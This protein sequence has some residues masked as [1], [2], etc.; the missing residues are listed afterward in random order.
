MAAKQKEIKKSKKMKNVSE[1][2]VVVEDEGRQSKI[3]GE[4]SSEIKAKEHKKQL[5]RLQEKDPEFYQFLQE[6][7]KELLEFDEEDEDAETEVDDEGDKIRVGEDGYE[8]DIADIDSTLEKED[9]SSKKVITT[10]MVDL[11][12]SAIREKTT[13]GAVR[14]LMKAFRTACHYGDDDGDDSSTKFSIMSSSVFN[15]IMLF[16]LNEMDR[17]FRALFDLPSSGGKKEMIIELMGTKKWKNYNHLVKSYFGNALHILNQMTD[18]EMISLTLKRLKSSSIFLAAFPSLLRRYI[19]VVIHFWGTGGDALP[20]VSFLFI[21]DLCIRVGSDCLDECFKGMYKAYVMNCQNVNATKLQHMQFLGNCVIEL[22]GVDLPAAYQHAFSFIRQLAMVLQDALSMKTDKA[23]STSD[24]KKGKAQPSMKRKEVFRKVYNWKF[25]NCLELW[26]GAICAYSSEADLR[27]LAYPL[28]QI[29]SGASRLVPTARYFPLRL[30]CVRMLNR[31]A[32]STGTFI[33]VSLLLLDMLDMK[34][35]NRPP[36]GGAGKAEDL[37]T[38]L[39]VSKST[40]R[41]KAFQEAYVLSVVD[42]VAEHLAIWSY[43]VAFHEL[44]FIPAVRLRNFCKSTK[45]ERFRREMRELIRQIEANAEFTNQ[46]RAS[47]S[48]LPND[49]AAEFFLED[50]K[51]S[52]ASPLSKYVVTLRQR[53]KQRTES[54]TGSSVLVGENSSAFGVKISENDEDDDVDDEDGAAVF[55]N[56]SWLP[57]KK[58]KTKDHVEEKT[59]KKKKRQNDDHNGAAVDEDIVEDLILSSDE[60]GD[61]GENEK[62]D[63]GYEN[64]REDFPSPRANSSGKS[65]PKKHHSKKRKQSK[66]LPKKKAHFGSAKTKR[67]KK[68][69]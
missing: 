61:E 6:H 56:S 37:R 36:T 46:K 53:A 16:V 66:I 51:K 19:K 38:T 32:E 27:P 31:L 63:D 54:L 1:E 68:A 30:R 5:Q 10:A 13:V 48:F 57:E 69:D 29:I 4:M 44:S 39:K 21:R 26:T 25:I 24:A 7:D 17:I 33:P 41:T 60:D 12:C 11:W 43:S 20:V 42:E 64:E 59:K 23:P 2:S 18:T 40:L 9:K 65:A 62:E 52:G 55:A 47:T 22:L 58:F 3:G 14:S 50:E 49:P 15:K 28:T 45:V 34:E 67:M 35:L 8:D